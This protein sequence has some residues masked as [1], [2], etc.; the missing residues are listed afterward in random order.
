MS[1]SGPTGGA[2]EALL[3]AVV[4]GAGDAM[5]IIDETGQILYANDCAARQYGHL[6]EELVGKN[7]LELAHPDDVERGI[8][9]LATSIE[10][11]HEAGWFAPP[12]LARAK[13]RDGSY[14]YVAITGSVIAR[15]DA[16]TYLSVLLRPA[17]DFVAMHASLRS[18]VS[19][20]AAGRTSPTDLRTRKR[21]ACRSRPPVGRGRGE[22]QLTS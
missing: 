16:H 11:D 2:D 5:G 13:S 3:A 14:R 8:E 22:I 7:L 9:M 19:S 10:G 6:A 15:T 18:M 12:V 4:R 1:G 21:V 20:S 17:D